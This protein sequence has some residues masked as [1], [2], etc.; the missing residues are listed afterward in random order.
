VTS[1]NLLVLCMRVAGQVGLWNLSQPILKLVLFYSW[2]GYKYE[3]N[4]IYKNDQSNTRSKIMSE[5]LSEKEIEKIIA[6]IIIEK[7]DT[8]F[9]TVGMTKLDNGEFIWL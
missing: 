9:E 5:N 2:H 4:S 7:I 8:F 3:Y 6:E 1:I